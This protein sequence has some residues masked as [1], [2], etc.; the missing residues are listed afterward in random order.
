MKKEKKKIIQEYSNEEK[1]EKV[2]A[3]SQPKSPEPRACP[4]SLLII[5]KK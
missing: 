2:F 5:H 4:M 3:L 1:K